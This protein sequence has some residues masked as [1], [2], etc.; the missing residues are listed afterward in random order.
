MKRKIKNF[1]YALTPYAK[2]LWLVAYLIAAAVLWPRRELLPLPAPMG[3]FV[4][5]AI[6]FSFLFLGAVFLCD[7]LRRPFGMARRAENTFAT[8]GLA[9]ARGE[10]PRLR[11]V[12]ADREKPHG[13]VLEV[14]NR[15]ISIADFDE[16]AHRLEAGLGGRI[17]RME[18]G[19]KCQTTR[20]YLLPMK[21]I[22]PTII[23]PTDEALGPI[24]VGRLINLLVV[25]GTGTGKTVAIKTI[26]GKIAQHQPNPNPIVWLLDFKC[27]DFKA[28]TALPHYYGYTDCVQG[29]EDYYAAFKEAQTS[30]VTGEPQY[31]VCDEWGSLM[32]S[33]P[34][35]EAERCK[36]LMAE[37]LA[38]G[39]AYKFIPIIGMQ[40]CDANYFT[41]GARDNFQVRLALG[42]LSPEGRRMVFPDN[43]EQITNCRKREGHLYIDG[44]GVEKVKMADIADLDALDASILAAMPKITATGGADGE[45]EREPADPP[46][47]EGG[48]LT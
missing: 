27:L 30:G 1:S 48:G 16:K 19:R 36:T 39:R 21:Y 6:L 11:S 10:I 28:Y 22:H 43:V 29:L 42:N 2:Y 45:A 41:D 26:M 46:V 4:L 15:G 35:K 18:Y 12:R 44:V 31:L 9:N 47:A 24:H 38:L 5:D 25:G 20:L 13:R 7:L 40:R 23:N 14:R 34:K 33:L 32:T 3:G 17:Y 8:A 37:L